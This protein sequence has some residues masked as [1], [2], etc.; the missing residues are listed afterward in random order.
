MPSSSEY[1]PYEIPN[2]EVLITVKTYPLPSNKYGE[3]VCTAGL[4]H[5]GKWI[6]VYPVPFL[7]LPYEK[8]YSKYQWITLDLVKNTNDFR[9]ESYRPRHEAERI[10]IG[11]QI[12]TKNYW[13]ERKKYVFKEVFSSMKDLIVLARDTPQKSLAT[14][15]PLHIVDFVIEEQK[16][17]EWPQQWRDYMLQENSSK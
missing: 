16:D 1:L 17:R 14:L 11:E 15:K 12:K 7:D 6:R 10:Q 4:L 13:A 8:Q 5:D 2:A 9:P 3:L